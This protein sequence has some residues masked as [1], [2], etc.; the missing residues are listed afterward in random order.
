M[1]KYAAAANALRP[2]AVDLTPVLTAVDA[3]EQ[4]LLTA[5]GSLDFDDLRAQLEQ[6]VEGKLTAL[7]SALVSSVTTAIESG[8]LSTLLAEVK[9]VTT[10]H[11]S[12]FDE[13]ITALAG[14]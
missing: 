9:T 10:A 13:F 14:A 3:S 11:R 5:L 8:D 7:E 4:S 2:T 6:A 1:S 12:E